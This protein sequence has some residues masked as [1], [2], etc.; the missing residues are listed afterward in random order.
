MLLS[1]QKNV[2][3]EWKFLRGSIIVIEGNIA[4]GKSTLCEELVDFLN[5]KG[6]NAKLYKEPILQDYL[7]MFILNQSQYAFGFQMTMLVENQCMYSDAVDFTKAG[8]IAILD[9]SFLGNQVFCRVQYERGNIT[10][11]EFKVY[12]SVYKRMDVFPNPDYIIYLEVDPNVNIQ[13]CKIRDRS[14]ESDNYDFQYFS[15][16]NRVYRKFINN[17]MGTQNILVF[18]WNRNR[19]LQEQ[20]DGTYEIL[21]GLKKNFVVK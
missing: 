11:Q 21:A 13:R 8:G 10:D 5:S 12:Q 14:C 18:D 2:F 20:K 9:R 6:F 16:L 15:D 1:P 3:S 19:S 4:S 7:D 17:L